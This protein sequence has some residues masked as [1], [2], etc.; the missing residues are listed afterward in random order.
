MQAF[1][2]WLTATPVRAIA[3]A[4][5]LAFLALL[6]PFGSWLPG[7][8]LVLLALRAGPVPDWA[9]GV[10]AALTL[11]WSLSSA[12]AGPIPAALVTVALVVPP[13]LIGRMLARGG[14]LNLTFQA[15]TLGVLAF[16]GLVHAVLADPPGVWRPFLE[17][18]A[19]EL[20][21]MG[22]VISNVGSGQRPQEADLIAASASRMWGVVCWLLLLNTMVAA[23]VGLWWQ[24][25]VTRTSRLG[26]AF[27]QLKAGRTLAILAAVT[28]MLTL[29]GG[30]DWPADATWVFLGAFVLQGLAVLHAARDSIGFS[31]AWLVATYVL[32]FVPFTTLLVSGALAVFGFVDNW[33]PLRERFAAGRPGSGPPGPGPGPGA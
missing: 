18:F 24:G 30:S 26:P 31:T 28:V 29:V 33:F 19:A 27:R 11:L 32:L 22:V 10:V 20:D 16:L 12:G 7:A 4:A 14:S 9:A 25:L 8:L 15:T 21:R 3:G 17:N 1:A 2:E 5:L 13:V 23:F 6:L